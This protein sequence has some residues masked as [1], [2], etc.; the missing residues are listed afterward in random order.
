VDTTTEFVVPYQI[1]P[2]AWMELRRSRVWN[3][4]EE[5]YVIKPPHKHTSA[6]AV[7]YTAD[8]VITCGAC[9]PMP[10]QTAFG[11]MDKKTATEVAVFLVGES[12]Y[13]D[14][15][16]PRRALRA[17]TIIVRFADGWFESTHGRRLH[18]QRRDTEWYL[19]FAGGR[20]WIRR[21][22]SPASC[23]TRANDYSPLRG[24]VVRIHS[25]TP[26]S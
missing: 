14:G 21:R 18:K 6:S 16:R 12:G 19:F 13:D 9:A 24:R 17:P 1:T 4:L 8:A 10:Y 11:G 5:R 22:A 26:A 25:R 3:P 15:L 2:K 20:E 7:P 23:A